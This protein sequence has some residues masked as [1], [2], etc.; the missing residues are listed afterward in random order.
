[1]TGEEGMTVVEFA[2]RH[3]NICDCDVDRQRHIQTQFAG[4]IEAAMVHGKT[5]CSIVLDADGRAAAL[6]DVHPL[7]VWE[8][9]EAEAAKVAVLK[10]MLGMP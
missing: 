9:L 3:A 2:E 10:R 5:V 4:L 7:E 8:A 6:W 1:M